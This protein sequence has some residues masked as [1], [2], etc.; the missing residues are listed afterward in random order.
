MR[1]DLQSI[2]DTHEKPFLIIDAESKIVAANAAFLS[3]YQTSLSEVLGQNC[4][5]V[6]H[7]SDRPCYESGEECPLQRVMETGRP[8]SCLH[9]HEHE[10]KGHHVHQ[11]RVKGFPLR[12]ADG[13]LYL[14]EVMEE[15]AVQAE[16][17]H[18][19][20]MTGRSPGFLSVLESM[21]KGAKSDAPILLQGET[22]TGKEL[23]AKFIHEHSLRS[24]G[25]MMT[26]DCTVLT[27]E[28]VESELFG[29]EKGAFTGSVGDRH[30]LFKLADGG[31]L[32]LDEIGEL[33]AELQTKLLRVLESGEFRRVGGSS[34]IRSDVRII[35]AT[36]RD[37]KQEVE[38]GRFR[39]D[40]YYRLA[41]LTV[42]IPALR[43]RSE[44]IPA[45][46]EVLLKRIQR[47]GQPL[48]KISP[49]AMRLLQA[50]PFPGN[51]RE[52]R[53]ILQAAASQVS[54]PVIEASLVARLIGLPKPSGAGELPEPSAGMPVDSGTS[55][56]QEVERAHLGRLVDQFGDNRTAIAEALGVSVRT[57][58]RK[59][60]RYGLR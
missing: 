54:G 60:N 2:V 21:Q 43:E 8:H 30:G 1:K 20:C 40:L 27:R 51:I 59:L 11:V 35:C 16:D 32:F 50:Y 6:T 19:D 39:Q 41:I 3:A 34:L 26:L 56:L 36:N 53:N 58:Y 37:L 46:V 22:G 52:L 57:V 9:I 4:Y 24:E 49:E 23:A 18:D 10:D 17:K 7:G 5:Q 42:R 28:L 14:G 12:L 29:H 31:S 33:P 55:S 45:L 47:P 44:D 48:L 13:N 25:P 15:I 38:R